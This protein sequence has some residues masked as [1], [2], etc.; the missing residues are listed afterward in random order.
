MIEDSVVFEAREIAASQNL[1]LG[2]VISQLA[3]RGLDSAPPVELKDG[4]PVFHRP[5]STTQIGLE[6]VLRA[7]EDDG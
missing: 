4:L 6:A 1:S 7:E 5:R 2:E 3:R